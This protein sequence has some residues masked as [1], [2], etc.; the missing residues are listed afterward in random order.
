MRLDSLEGEAREGAT[1]RMSA[2]ACG[3]A[4]MVSIR[5]QALGRGPSV[6]MVRAGRRFVEEAR[7]RIGGGEREAIADK[8]RE[9]REKGGGGHGSVWSME[10]GTVASQTLIG[11]NGFRLPAIQSE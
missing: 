9:K 10:V 8:R 1:L 4:G 2:L 11:Q 3:V 6:D 5:A 7:C